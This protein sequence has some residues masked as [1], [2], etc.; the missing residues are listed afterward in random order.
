MLGKTPVGLTHAGADRLPDVQAR[1]LQRS[2]QLLLRDVRPLVVLPRD[3]GYQL[4]QGEF[5]LVQG[6][7]VGGAFDGLFYKQVTVGVLEDDLLDD[8]VVV[9]LEGELDIAEGGNDLSSVG[10]EQLHGA[11]LT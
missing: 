8:G 11:V 7:G 3:D 9:S 5:E 10:L 4:L 6:L 2:N 1:P